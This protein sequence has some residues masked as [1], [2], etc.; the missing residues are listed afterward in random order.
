MRGSGLLFMRRIVPSF[1]LAG[2]RPRGCSGCG[3][4]RG[5]ARQLVRA[6]VAAAQRPDR[7][8]V[9]AV[10]RIGVR[11]R[12]AKR[13]RC[14]AAGS[15]LGRLPHERMGG[16][17]C[18]RL[19]AAVRRGEG[20]ARASGGVMA[21]ACSW[22]VRGLF[23]MCGAADHPIE[24]MRIGAM[25]GCL[26]CGP[27]GTGW[28][29]DAAEPSV[30]LACG[31][32]LRQRIAAEMARL[33]LVRCAAVFPD[34]PGESLLGHDERAQLWCLMAICAEGD[35]PVAA[36]ADS[37]TKPRQ[38]HGVSAWI[39]LSAGLPSGSEPVR[40]LAAWLSRLKVGCEAP[41]WVLRSKFSDFLIPFS[42]LAV[43]RTTS[44]RSLLLC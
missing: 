4:P 36:M 19:L 44:K 8:G 28:P 38:L 22:A 31:S 18:R 9:W 24:L 13:E 7:L 23:W 12:E 35:P 39:Q 3:L 21:G 43:G 29:G 30:A 10:V 37:A 42:G 16:L 15:A 2:A 40:C 5:P 34:A 20:G 26:A 25:A 14:E 27:A 32:L 1:L 17:L 6:V 11:P 41:R 33:L